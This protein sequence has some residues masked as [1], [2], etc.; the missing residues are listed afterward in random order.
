MSPVP[1]LNVPPTLP[2]NLLPLDGTDWNRVHAVRAVDGD[3]VR[4]LRQQLSWD[5]RESCE[6][7]DSLRMTH[8][9]L[10]V[11][12]DDPEEL[13]GGISARLVNLDTPERGQDGY[14]VAADDLW[15][16]IER[17]CDRLRCITYDAGGGFDRV[18]IDLYVLAEDG[19]TVEDSAS[20]HMLREGWSPY[21]KGA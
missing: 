14:D 19:R 9:E 6:I 15:L 16:W 13:A 11:V 3:T 18:L 2:P 5:L 21:V 1:P 7:G 12:E 8:W 10:R 17:N 4:I 20:Q